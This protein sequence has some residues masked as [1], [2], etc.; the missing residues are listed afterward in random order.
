MGNYRP[1]N[2]PAWEIIDP[3]ITQFREIVDP[4]M[5]NY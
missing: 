2:N 1:N 5:G 4:T 3:T